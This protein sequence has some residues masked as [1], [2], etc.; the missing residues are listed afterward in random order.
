MRTVSNDIENAIELSGSTKMAVQA[1]IQPS[2]VY[3][4]SLTNDNPFDSDDY[5]EATDTPRPQCMCYSNTNSGAVT[6]IVD[7]SGDINA[8]V[9]G[10]G[11]IT[12]LGVNTDPEVNPGIYDLGTG[13]ARLYYW[14][15]A[16]QVIRCDV[17]MSTF[18]VSNASGFTP[19]PTEFDVDTG[20][21]HGISSNE[22]VLVY[23]TD[24]GGVSAAYYNGASYKYWGRRFLSP[25]REMDDGYW[26]VYSAAVKFNND[27]YVYITDMDTG[28]VKAVHYDTTKDRW[29]DTW[30][31]VPATESRFCVGNARVVNGYIHMA[32]QFHRTDD[33]AEAQ[34]WSLVVRSLT[35][36]NF[37]WDRHT[38]MSTLGYQFQCENARQAHRQ[39]RRRGQGHFGVPA[40]S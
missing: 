27:I 15:T 7:D 30:I 2:R 38:G 28:E 39:G 8:M 20:S 14:D 16:G 31:A 9:Q 11:S 13:T 22:F 23:R 29:S 12:D 5:N 10:S 36:K 25:N 24:L 6:F 1:T 21:L 4:S 33:L 34:K 17:N 35:G 32:G 19:N 37:S 26:T 40:R 3:F 18:G